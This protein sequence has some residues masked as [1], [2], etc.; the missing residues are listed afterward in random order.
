MDPPSSSS[1]SSPT[2]TT[3][4]TASAEIKPQNAFLTIGAT[5]VYFEEDWDSGIGG[6]LWSTGLAMATYLAQH[7]NH[8][9]QNLKARLQQKRQRQ[10]QQQQHPQKQSLQ[11]EIQ[12]SATNDKDDPT[13]TTT[14]LSLLELGSGNGFLSVC[15][16]A[17]GHADSLFET[18]V[19][20]D[21]KEHLALMART[22][23]ANQHIVDRRGTIQRAGNGQ[24]DDT[25]P[26]TTPPPS[27]PAIH[28]VQVKILE[29]QWGVFGGS[30]NTRHNSEE[31]IEH[32]L[33][34]PSTSPC[35]TTNDTIAATTTV[36]ATTFDY[37]IGSDVAYRDELHDPLIASLL[38]YSNPDT[39]SLIGVTMSDTKPIFFQK[40]HQAGF[41][42]ERFAD[43]LLDPQFRGSTFGIFILQK[44]VV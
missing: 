15:F 28:P 25:I 29:H 19:L 34:L 17:L 36:P 21:T 6:G 11:Q 7:S 39:I 13:I 41:R 27:S 35:T 16:L 31:E 20:T 23:D 10:K 26:S 37:I 40:L 3:P 22:L 14:G 12:Y 42:Y 33:S 2:K 9:S 8:A 18:V 44:E 43:H 38:H 24:V 4:T 1:S 32:D 5:P 30:T